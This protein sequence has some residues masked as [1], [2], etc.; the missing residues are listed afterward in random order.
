MTSE[1]KAKLVK[2][3]DDMD[4]DMNDPDVK[5]MIAFCFLQYGVVVV[6]RFAE[7]FVL[8]VKNTRKMKDSP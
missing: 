5:A 6:R 3:F 1:E 7:H 2:L 4:L 8:A